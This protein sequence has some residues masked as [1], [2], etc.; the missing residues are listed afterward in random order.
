MNSGFNPVRRN[1]N[2]GTKRQ[3]HGQNN[4]LSIPRIAG[5][6]RLWNEHL[7]NYT[8]TQRFVSGRSVTFLVED[9]HGGCL[10]ACSVDDICHV[11]KHVPGA[12]WTGLDTFVLRQSTRKQRILNPAWG[13][14]FYW[15]DFGQAGRE[16]VRSGPAVIL[17]AIDP[18]QTL[19]W[20]LSLGPQDTEELKRLRDDGHTVVRDTHA[21]VFSVTPT[22]AR[23]TQLYRTLLHEIGH[24]VDFRKKVEG[25]ADRGEQDYSDLYDA[26]FSRPRDE[27]EAFAHRYADEAREKLFRF[28]VFPFDPI[29]GSAGE[30]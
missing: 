8:Q 2:I 26:Y 24:W 16:T 28:G 1:R 30:N 18:E 12:D 27:R 23:A 11:L 29:D 25:P 6:E 19:K 7:G 9:N 15:A 3:G 5:A 17:E 14:L 10:H 20:G 22:S 13:R 4:R 21:Y